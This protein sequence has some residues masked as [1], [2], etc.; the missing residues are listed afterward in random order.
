MTERNLD[1]GELPG[2]LQEVRWQDQKEDPWLHLCQ[3]TRF[4][5]RSSFSAKWRIR[6]IR[7]SCNPCLHGAHSTHPQDW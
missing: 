3:K 7:K 2:I 6:R 5:E 4:G 1:A